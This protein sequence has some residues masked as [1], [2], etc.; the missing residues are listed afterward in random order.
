VLLE[1]WTVGLCGNT[2]AP[3]RRVALV[4][5][6]QEIEPPALAATRIWLERAADP[7]GAG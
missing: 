5:D 6:L 7:L 1:S 4:N 3:L 2:A